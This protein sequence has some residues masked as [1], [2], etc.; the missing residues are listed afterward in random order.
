MRPTPLL[1]L[2]HQSG[3]PLVGPTV[4]AGGSAAKQRR[5]GPRGASPARI[6]GHAAATL[7]VGCCVAVA[8]ATTAVAGEPVYDSW[9]W[10]VWGRELA[11]FDLDTSSGPSWKPLAVF[12][13][14]LLSLGGSAAPA[15]WLV[16]VQTAWLLALVLAARLAFALTPQLD[17]RLRLTAAAFAAGSLLLLADGATLWT[18]QA[19]AGMSE[20]VAVALSLG[21]ATAALA[22]RARL[23][24]ALAALTAL[25]RPEAWPLL[26]AYGGW[27][28]RAEPAQRP[29]IA[30]TAIVVPALWLVPDLLA[31]GDAPGGATRAR[32][33]D[34]GMP[35]KQGADVLARAA[36]MPLAVVWPLALAGMFGTR[37]RAGVAARTADR[38][39]L[40]L[41][42]AAAAWIV[43]VA[44]MAAAGYSGLA[45]YCAPAVAILGIVA[46][47]G[48]AHLLALAR[49]RLVVAALLLAAL[50][51]AAVQLPER[52]GEL[53]EGLSTAAATARSND[54]LRAL[55]R[56]VG[57]ERLLRCGTLATSD[58]R[59]RTALAWQ[60]GVPLKRVVS[61]AGP[62]PRPMVLI[63]GPDA[64]ARLR[65]GMR[66]GAKLLAERGEWRVYSQDCGTPR[67]LRRG[68]ART[69]R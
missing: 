52:V 67:P 48:L 28:W 56:A 16:L 51:A 64:S 7:V 61:V 25:T 31:A 9:A 39:R 63:T 29:W 36:A 17:R 21:A 40:A 47:A 55:T 5:G 13:T 3:Q 20:P 62:A 27:L 54:R 45:R 18:R 15:L 50:L 19:A 2:R 46:A 68:G 44:A 32:R 26:L 37:S 57:R 22:R 65:A 23:A 53:G 6:S 1:R 42:A 69:A 24:L 14:A 34:T 8:V 30:S 4:A 58:V 12:V 35:L 59:V 43:I 41:G 60:L 49:R 33:R 11:A 38:A 66:S 10:L